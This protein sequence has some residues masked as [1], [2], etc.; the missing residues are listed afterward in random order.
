MSMRKPRHNKGKLRLELVTP[1]LKEG[2]AKVLTK[3]CEKYGD[4]D[5]EKGDSWMTTYASMLRHLNAWEKREDID[6][7]SGLPHLYHIGAN[8]QFLI[9]YYKRNVGIDDRIK[10]CRQ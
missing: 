3:N 7:D 1:E 10:K 9:T 6:P 4:R 8:I 5:W 2:I